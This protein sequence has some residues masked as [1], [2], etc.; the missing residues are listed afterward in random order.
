MSWLLAAAV[1]RMS[2]TER[3]SSH[4]AAWAC[5]QARAR[6]VMS[7]IIIEK[8]YTKAGFGAR[9]DGP[10]PEPEC[11][12]CPRTLLAYPGDLAAGGFDEAAD[13][14]EELLGRGCGGEV[15]WGHTYHTSEGRKSSRAGLR[16]VRESLT[17]SYYAGG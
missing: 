4:W 8:V 6:A 10:K 5:P 1:W 2:L 11:G 13:V 14:A 15:G 16:E 3:P 9:G 12:L 17:P 7:L